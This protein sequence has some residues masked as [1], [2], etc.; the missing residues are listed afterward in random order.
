MKKFTLFSISVIFIFVIFTEKS[1]AIP[2][3]T[4]KYGFNCNMCHT[5]YPKLNDFGQRF[6]DNGYQLPGQEGKEKTVMEIAPP[7]AL[8]S[9]AGVTTYFDSKGTTSGFKLYGLDVFAAGV[10]H[11]NISALV[12][13]TPRIDEPSADYTGS[14]NGSNPS[15]LA[16]LESANV[17]FSNIIQDAFNIRVGR[18]EPS[19]Q[20]F[21]QRRSLYIMQPYNIYSF[22]SARNSNGFGNNQLGIEAS[23]HFRSGFKYSVGFLNGTGPDPDNNL[24]KDIFAHLSKTFGKGDGQSAGQKVGIFGYYGWQPTSFTGVTISPSGEANGK[25]NKPFYRFGGNLSLNWKTLNLQ[26]L[27]IMGG[28]DKVFNEADSTQNY[29]FTGGF[30]QLDWAGL[31]DNRIIVSGLFNWIQPP[32]Y[33]KSRT[34]KAMSGLIRYYLGSWTSVNVALHAEFTHRIFGSENT[35]SD[36][37][38]TLLV[39]FGF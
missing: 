6:R 36:D 8:R 18:F 13:Y 16:S 23:G 34:Y 21:S 9:N 3:F 10:L 26:T 22:T 1:S 39:D 7:I 19:Y 29:N 27:F 38:V 4:R 30:V 20:L 11:K 31:M 2:A 25:E 33:D 17:V 28:D 14:S 37:M 24:A 15:Q 5:A 32:S 35:I 12:V